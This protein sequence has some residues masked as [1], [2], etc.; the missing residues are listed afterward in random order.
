[1][2]SLKSRTALALFALEILLAPAA[3]AQCIPANFPV[4]WLQQQENAGGHTIARHVGRTDA[5]L[6][7]RLHQNPNIAA[8]STYTDLP[9]AEAFIEAGLTVQGAVL[10][11]WAVNAQVGA[12]RADNFV[13]NN[14]VGRV[15]FPPPNLQNIVNS[16]LFRTVLQATGQGGCF[17][18]TSFPTRPPNAA[19]GALDSTSTVTAANPSATPV[20]TSD[21]Q[22]MSLL[23]YL[24]GNFSDSDLPDEKAAVEGLSK[25]TMAWY[26]EVLREGRNVLKERFDWHQIPNYANRRF[27]TE[28]EALVWLERMM[29]TLEFAIKQTES[30]Q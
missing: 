14:V 25:K 18:L 22:W 28:D 1:M 10:N 30:G 29:D 4:G 12:R 24:A 11:Q 13:G 19:R 5:Q 7:Q 26:K 6:V 21:L 15:A 8:A 20:N 2:T 16:N 9:T 17:L 27:D 23:G 3:L